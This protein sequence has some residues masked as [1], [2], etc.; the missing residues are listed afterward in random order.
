[1]PSPF[2]DWVRCIIRNTM[3]LAPGTRL[4]GYEVLG[5]LG[6]GGMGEV[7]RARDS[8]LKRDVAIK[9][10]PI[11]VSQEP[12]RLHRF[13]QE[14][15]A[16][17]ALNHPNILA[18]HQFGNHNGTPYLV[19]E[20]LEGYTLRQLLQRGPLPVRKVIE[21]SIQIAH[22]LAAAHEKGI[23]HRDLKPENLFVT[24]DGR[25]KILDFGL[26]K[27]AQQ[28]GTDDSGPTQTHVTQPG[29]VLGTVGYMSPEQVR[30]KVADHRA[31][32]FAFGAIL[33]EMLVGKRAFERTTSAETMTAILNDDPPA[34]SQIV[35]S[36]PPGLQRVVH[37]CF[38]KSPEQRFQ[39][40][41]DLAFALEAISESGISGPVSIAVPAQRN[42]RRLLFWTTGMVAVLGMAAAAYFLVFRREQ[43][44]SLRI[45][46]YT[47][48]THDGHAG[49]V[50]GTDGARLYLSNA[51]GSLGQVSVSGGAIQPIT[52]S[53]PKPL[54]LDI[55]PDGSTALVASYGKGLL[56]TEPLYTVQI[57]GGESRYIAD[58]AGAA[59]SPSGDSIVYFTANGD[60][61]TIHSDGTTAHKFASLG[62]LP[63]AWNWSPDGG[64][65]RYSVDGKLWEMS[66]DGSHPHELLQGWRTPHTKCCGTWSPNGHFYTFLSGPGPQ[67]WAMDERSGLF[68]RSSPHL[69]QLT[70]GPISWAFPIFSKD[71]KKIFATGWT[72]G[73]QLVRFDAKSKQ[74]QPYLS[75]ISAEFVV[76]SKDG[77]SV[78]YVTYPDH[79]LW[80]AN[81]DGSNRVQL[82]APPLEPKLLSLS[83]D[84]TQILFTDSSRTG[85]PETYIVSFQ[86][87]TPRRLLPDDDG[88]ETD[89]GWSPDGREIAFSNSKE[90]GRDRN[91]TIRI[92][93]VSSHQITTLPGSVGMFSPRWSPD[94]K[95]IA[96]DTFDSLSIHVFNI[97]TQQW[98]AVHH[99]LLGWFAWSRD[100]QSLFL[101]KYTDDRGVYQIPSAGGKEVRIVDMKDVPTTGAYGLWL[102]LDPTDA[103]LL[104]RDTGTSDI[105]AL[106][107][108]TK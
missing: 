107:L 94:G 14:A 67:I 70:S 71:G 42:S 5:P 31:D 73:G 85:V 108:E 82:S 3:P 39:S 38:E 101:L 66:S 30:G 83:P 43:A 4:E 77:N 34:A 100:S 36:T 86:D 91:S 103:P 72:K 9:V 18:V 81:R 105:Y 12:D 62:G 79:V 63:D 45:S 102:G 64:T 57:L 51:I 6:S 75:G 53:L 29:M 32:I 93:N 50:A 24:K 54:L 1:M 47:Q 99:G 87:G 69:F 89:A 78:A 92:L 90:A 26:A 16:A 40:A 17:A 41:S 44:P 28:S 37:R 25:V 23:V 80:K 104:L 60:V 35:P 33:Y 21:Y 76:F 2:G 74:L 49:N 13:Q 98:S 11:V 27:L 15:Q 48:I 61:W 46:D 106:T 84:G 59:F 96:A 68:R 8:A 95:S 58:T 52:L 19:S 10:L 65:I 88:P 56:P 20:L 7:Y 97:K 55:S 22:G